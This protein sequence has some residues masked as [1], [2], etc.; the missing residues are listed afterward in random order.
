MSQHY[1]FQISV[2]TQYIEDQSEPEKERYVFAYTINISNTGEHGAKLDSR[3]WVITDANGEITEV[4]GLG[5][6]GE[7]PFIE[8]GK[9][10]EYSSG[11]VLTT[12]IGSMEG[13]YYMVGENG[14]EFN[15]PI[16]VFSLAAPGVLH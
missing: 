10:Y 3:R 4:E 2:S 8:A 11:A 9:S 5:V 6:V 13:T 1:Q 12:P 16:P 15:A 14:A 7:Q